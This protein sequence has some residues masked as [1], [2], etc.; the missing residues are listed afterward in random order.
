MNQKTIARPASTEG[1]GIHTGV[2]VK[3]KFIPAEASSGINFVRVDI[4]G[5]PSIKAHISNVLNMGLSPRRT[6]IG[7]GSNGVEIHTVEHL[8][9][10]LCG[11]GID[12]ITVEVDNKELP[13]L[14][15]SA[16]PY[17]KI[18]NDAGIKE[19]D[20]PRNVIEIKEPFW[21]EDDNSSIVVL[22]DESLKISYSLSYEKSHFLR[23]QYVR[24]R[25]NGPESFE[26]EIA[27]SRTFCVEEEA[28]S[29]LKKGFGK[30]ANYKNTLVVG[31]SGVI[32]NELRFND[33][34]ARH[35]I[36]DLL[37]DMHLLGG[38]L[39]GHIIAVRSGHTLNMRLASK[40]YS[41]RSLKALP[42][43]A[44]PGEEMKTKPPLNRD[45]IMKILP[46]RP[47]FLFVDSIEEIEEDKKI[48]G[49]KNLSQDE[50]FFKGHFPG[51]PVMPGVLI[52]EAMAQTAGVLMLSKKT[53]IGKIAYFVSINNVK[54]RKVV[55]PGDRVKLVAEVIKFRGKVGVVKGTAYVGDDLAAE[56]DLL[57]MLGDN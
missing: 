14:D 33:E 40:I 16:L 35:K 32:E 5:K 56:S 4:P 11:L 48:V 10:A 26:K 36:S 28:D 23:S 8:M 52:V 13:A 49:Y 38:V 51:R 41:N 2:S 54:F 53:S 42:E 24:F 29:L 25:L 39:K 47:P 1:V 57:F 46:H 31:S 22:P 27:P 7:I 20:K 21:V 19:L 34:F 43:R 50:Y 6:S 17:L 30:G 45:D 37:G 12:N 44:K 9:A 18:L 3:L 15:G 55:L